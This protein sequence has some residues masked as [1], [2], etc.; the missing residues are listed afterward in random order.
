MLNTVQVELICLHPEHRRMSGREVGMPCIAVPAPSAERLL[1]SCAPDPVV[2]ECKHVTQSVIPK[3]PCCAE[4]GHPTPYL[5][6][7]RAG[8]F[9]CLNHYLIITLPVE[10]FSS[11]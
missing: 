9:H 10:Q 11:F 7:L 8:F 1:R 5:N 6:C 4:K 3:Y 2:K